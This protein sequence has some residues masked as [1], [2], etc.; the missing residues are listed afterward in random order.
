MCVECNESGKICLIFFSLARL[1]RVRKEKQNEMEIM[2]QRTCVMRA[3]AM[4]SHRKIRGK[5][6]VK[7]NDFE[8]KR[9]EFCTVKRRTCFGCEHDKEEKKQHYLL[10]QWLARC[11]FTPTKSDVWQKISFSKI[12]INSRQRR[13]W[14][15]DR[16]VK[17]TSNEFEF[18]LLAFCSRSKSAVKHTKRKMHV[19]CAVT[20]VALCWARWG[21][22]D[23]MRVC[24]EQR[25]NERT[26]EKIQCFCLARKHRIRASSVSV[27]NSFKKLVAILVAHSSFDEKLNDVKEC[28]E[29]L[30]VFVSFALIRQ[31]L[32]QCNRRN[33]FNENDANERD[34]TNEFEMSERAR[35]FG[36]CVNRNYGRRD[37]HRS[38][39]PFSFELFVDISFIQIDS[40][41]WWASTVAE[42]HNRWIFSRK[43]P[44]SNIHFETKSEYFTNNAHTQSSSPSMDSQSSVDLSKFTKF[45]NKFTTMH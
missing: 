2:R 1:R 6:K 42:S 16:T 5:N 17:F 8:N 32:R 37:V 33:E 39:T 40:Y 13:R 34:A 36:R 14:N 9:N 45:E 22:I 35:R 29:A 18:F 24:V 31:L 21:A 4:T 23:A 44:A 26:S 25:V 19:H 43:K 12:K 3:L 15:D 20:S 11:L 30:D 41:N 10:N 7:M 38:E 28:Y 27:R